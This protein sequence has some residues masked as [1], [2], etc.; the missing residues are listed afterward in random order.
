MDD[1]IE[2]ILIAA[3]AVAAVI[4]VAAEAVI[5]VLSAT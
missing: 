4:W 2:T 3:A 5:H 1:K